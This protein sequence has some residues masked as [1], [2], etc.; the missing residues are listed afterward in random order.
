MRLDHI[1][2]N[3]EVV[4][5]LLIVV[6]ALLVVAT[7]VK[8]AGTVMSIAE[9]QR[10]VAGAI[11]QGKPDPNQV[12]S[13]MAEAKQL[14]DQLKIKNLYAPPPPKKNPVTEVRGI[15]GGEALIDGKWYKAG[16]KIGDAKI[17]AVEPTLVRVEWEAELHT[18][19]PI[20]AAGPQDDDKRRKDKEQRGPDRQPERRK[21]A[22]KDEGDKEDSDQ[23]RARM[24]ERARRQ[25]GR[26]ATMRARMR[27]PERGD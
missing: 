20:K 19:E 22:R 27:S 26:E 5:V 16:D 4:S 17:V 24:E 8:A 12:R 7:F 21:Q 18:F 1:K 25:Q 6:S 2:D 9:A 3:K 15:M 23:K 11:E 13:C 14:A 10:H